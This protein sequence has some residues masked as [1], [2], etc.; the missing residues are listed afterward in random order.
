MAK[1]FTILGIE[2][3]TLS[4]ISPQ[5]NYVAERLNQALVNEVRALSKK[6]WMEDKYRGQALNHAT[7][8]CKK[9][10]TCALQIRIP[11]EKV[12]GLISDDS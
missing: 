5:S 7:D 8:L 1:N 3:A 12:L 4:A 2:L 10:A 9:P 6:T 11:H